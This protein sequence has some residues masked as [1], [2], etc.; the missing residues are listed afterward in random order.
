MS[1][2]RDVAIEATDLRKV[3]R[4]GVVA[5][6]GVSLTVEWGQVLAYLGRNGSGKTTTVRIL[7][8]LT[9]AT[10]GS[11]TVAGFDVLGAPDALRRSVGVTM[12]EA[13]L[14]DLMTGREQLELAGR[15]IGLSVADSRARA[16]E[17]LEMV[18]LTDA[19]GRLVAT[20]SG[21]MRRRLDI[22]T[23]LLHNP[24]VLFLDEPTTGLDPQGRRT[25]WLT[26]RQL[27]E[28]GATI[29]LT[30]QY[31]EEAEEL[32][33]QVA[34]LEAG[35]VV[36]RGTPTELKA[37]LGPARLSLRLA[38]EVDPAVIDQMALS[39][40]SAGV[41]GWVNLRLNGDVEPETA[42]IDVLGR[43]RDA[44]IAVQGV[45]LSEP[46]LEDVFVEF[47]G[48]RPD[49]GVQGGS[50]SSLAAVRRTRGLVPGGS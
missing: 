17:L 8:T 32:A 6:D 7:T 31:L 14:D 39:V 3:Y 11:A 38:H 43:F 37:G 4:G 40:T 1:T 5:L 41:D 49:E 47:T 10:S 50:G 13:A 46:S 42:L 20:Y 22:T 36:A 24:R 25:L 28:A 30:T 29:F 35:R 16:D 9:R 15:L 27:R 18:G 34:I 12:Q 45:S 21:G 26:I 33:D 2:T 19:A 23:A 48:A 44:G